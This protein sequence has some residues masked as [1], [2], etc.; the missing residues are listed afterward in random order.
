MHQILSEKHPMIG[1]AMKFVNHDEDPELT[2]LAAERA[3]QYK[4]E[5]LDQ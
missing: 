3:T 4:L 1:E 2:R 5:T